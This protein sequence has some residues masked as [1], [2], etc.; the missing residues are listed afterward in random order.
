MRVTKA[1][2]PADRMFLLYAFYQT[3]KTIYPFLFVCGEPCNAKL[4]KARPARLPY[5]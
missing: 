3:F 2:D 4:S 5:V 1:R